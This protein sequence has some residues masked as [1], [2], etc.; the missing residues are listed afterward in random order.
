MTPEA[1]LVELLERVGA[2]R[3]AAVVVSNHELSEWP[4]TTVAAMKSRGLIT[5]ARPATSTVCYECERECVMP[6]HILSDSAHSPEALIVC[7]KRSDINRVP[8]P[9]SCL[10][11]WQASGVSVANL[12]VGLLDLR[13]SGAGDTSS[14]RWEIGMFKGVKY[15][16][17]LVLIADGQLTLSLAGHSIALADVLALEGNRFTVDKRT[18]IHLVDHPVAG[19]G[20]AE[21]AAQRRERLKKR[22]QAERTKGSKAFLKVVAEEEGISVSRLKQLLDS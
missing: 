11:Q 16:S 15:S 2:Q 19:A 3:G 4:S 6:V 22:V 7:D 14:G 1:A 13:R 8:V 5:K 12:L 17:H 10:E 21:S 20:D 18:L 9:I